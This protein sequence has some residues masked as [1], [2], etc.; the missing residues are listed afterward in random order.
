MASRT[1]VIVTVLV[2]AAL[3][4]IIYAMSVAFNPSGGA[5]SQLDALF[6]QNERDCPMWVERYFDRNLTYYGQ[7]H[8]AQECI[9]RYGHTVVPEGRLNELIPLHMIHPACH[10]E[11]SS[12]DFV[13]LAYVP[14]GC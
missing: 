3:I 13:P 12:P 14:D 11:P 9:E 5:K 8:I 7:M 6:L 1:D 2:F 4:A 10:A